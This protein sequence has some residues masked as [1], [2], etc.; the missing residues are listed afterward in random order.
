MSRRHRPNHRLAPALVA[1]LVALAAAPP[2]TCAGPRPAPPNLPQEGSPP[3]SAPSGADEEPVLG[4]PSGFDLGPA[5]EAWVSVRA[6]TRI[7]E[8]PDAAATALALVDTDTE[9]EVLARKGPW[10][11]VRYGSIRGWVDTSGRDSLPT[12]STRPAAVT[13]DPQRL[14]WARELLADTGE[15]TLGPFQL[16]TDVSDGALLR[17]MAEVAVA[18]EPAYRERYGL[19]PLPSAGE[20][21]VLFARQEDFDV[22]SRREGNLDDLEAHGHAGNGV[23]ALAVAE[24]SREEILALLIHEL[25]HLVNRRAL[26]KELPAWLEEGLAEDLSYSRITPSGRLAPGALAGWVRLRGMVGP[27]AR[28]GLTTLQRLEISGAHAALFQLLEG[29]SAPLRA[30]LEVLVDMPWSEVVSPPERRALL[31]PLSAFFLR[32]LLDGGDPRYREALQAYLAALAAGGQGDAGALQRRLQAPWPQLEG[33]LH[34][35]LEAL[36]AA[37]LP[38]EG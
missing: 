27:G 4:A 30:P 9:L 34:T 22:Y 28:G 10:V 37:A 6:D 15:A 19:E 8:E 25:T 7:R 11:Q 16:L 29:W 3:A 2:P 23:A 36:R 17:R 1:A 38:V 12:L 20:A 24:R 35:W 18:V 13:A 21:V 31:Y 26:G 5:D 33:E 14:E 32:F